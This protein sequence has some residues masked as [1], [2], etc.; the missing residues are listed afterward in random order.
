VELDPDAL[1]FLVVEREGMLAEHV[2][3]A[4][5]VGDAAVGH[6]DRALVERLGQQRPEVPGVLRG[7]HAGV[8]VALDGA[9]EVREV[10]H[11]AEEE[12]RG[13][14]ADEIPVALLGVELAGEAADVALGVGRAALARHGGEAD[15]DVGLL[16]DLGEELGLGVPG[17]V[18]RHGEVAVSAPALGVHAP[19]GDDLA[20][21]VGQLLQQPHILHHHRT[22]RAGCQG[23]F[24][25]GDGRA[26]LVG[27]FREFRIIHKILSSCCHDG[28]RL[29][30]REL[31]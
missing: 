29:G 3:V 26:D 22:A 12:G 4:E 18:V 8:G 27:K 25:L 24:I 1:V 14:V 21:E 16:A 10:V 31:K 28:R 23:V 19:L 9:V 5:A 11:V 20:V 15:E 7:A 30:G 6:D 2:H 13:V 17:D